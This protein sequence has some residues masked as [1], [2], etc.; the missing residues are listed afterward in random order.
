MTLAMLVAS[1]QGAMACEHNMGI[2]PGTTV[3]Q[4]IGSCENG[5]IEGDGVLIYKGSRAKETFYGSFEKGQFVRGALEGKIGLKTIR[6]QDGDFVYNDERHERSKSMRI[7]ADAAL[8]AS[9]ILE[10]QGDA[11]GAADYAAKNRDMMEKVFTFF[12]P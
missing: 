3:A 5:V 8:K 1:A 10:K 6:R 9:R 12:V 11:K 2:P 7:A 4:W